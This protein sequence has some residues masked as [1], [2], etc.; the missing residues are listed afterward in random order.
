MPLSFRRLSKKLPIFT[1]SKHHRN[2]YC[3]PLSFGESES[4]FAAVS[5]IHKARIISEG[6]IQHYCLKILQLESVL[7]S[8]SF[9]SVRDPAER[10]TFVHENALAKR[11]EFSRYFPPSSS[12]C[13]KSS[14]LHVICRTFHKPLML[15]IGPTPNLNVGILLS[16]LAHYKI[17][18]RSS[19][20]LINMLT[21]G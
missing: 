7:Q 3:L 9:F 18:D 8:A 5:P 17:T 19:I 6:L 15:L 1:V 16:F 2:L 11:C 13:R 21:G 14:F 12:S 4:W 20:Q 10:R